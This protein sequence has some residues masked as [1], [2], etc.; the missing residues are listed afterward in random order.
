MAGLER[1]QEMIAEGMALTEK[2]ACSPG[3]DRCLPLPNRLEDARASCTPKGRCR[4]GW[5]VADSGGKA[6][7][8]GLDVQTG[9][10]RLRPQVE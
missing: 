7:D 10:G 5:M 1:T 6:W 2:V 3:V 9:E 8:V 4:L